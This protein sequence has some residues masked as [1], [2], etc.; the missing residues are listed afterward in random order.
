MNTEA[1]HPHTAAAHP[2]A[3]RPMRRK[4]REIMDPVLIES[5]LQAEKL[6]HLAMS[7]NDMP[8]LVP[9]YFGWDGCAL[10]FHSASAGSKISILQGN[11]EVCFEISS[12]AGFIEA[13]DAC[14][15][16]A[17]HRTVIGFGRVVFIEDEAEKTR[18]LDLIVARFTDKHF[19]YPKENL[20]K[21]F[22]L[23]IDVH[24]MKGKQHGF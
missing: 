14:D 11:P 24:S 12:V 23:R 13:E 17:H 6:M 16:E 21:T 22:V 15:F 8:F 10:Y 5:V 20:A 7:Q 3:L 18:A 2:H 9:V 4:A 1:T 19:E